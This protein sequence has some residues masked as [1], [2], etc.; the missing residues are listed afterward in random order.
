MAGSAVLSRER[1]SQAR[2][3]GR[4]WGKKTAGELFSDKSWKRRGRPTGPL[5]MK[6]L[7]ER[8][9]PAWGC[10][11]GCETPC[12]AELIMPVI[13]A[14]FQGLLLHHPSMACSALARLGTLDPPYLVFTVDPKE[15]GLSSKRRGAPSALYSNTADGQRGLLIAAGCWS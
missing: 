5:V 14:S 13:P 6:Q 10:G 15:G 4:G 8:A 1:P 7:S 11:R 9:R 12:T 3:P 2:S